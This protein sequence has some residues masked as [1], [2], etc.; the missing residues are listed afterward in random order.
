MARLVS[1]TLC[2]F[3]LLSLIGCSKSIMIEMHNASGKAISIKD[4]NILLANL[5]SDEREVLEGDSHQGVF[6]IEHD[7][8]VYRYTIKVPSYDSS[9][10]HNDLG[11]YIFRILL[12]DDMIIYACDP[13]RF[14]AILSGSQ[15]A[16]W[17]G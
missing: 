4:G 11:R 16:A 8:D 1:V 2:G 13:K 15:A 7:S 17:G 5:Q 10:L 14:F 12:N 9:L 3:L 6:I